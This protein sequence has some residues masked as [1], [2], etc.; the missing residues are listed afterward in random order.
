MKTP[1]VK[2]INDII[3]FVFFG[4]M[5]QTQSKIDFCRLL[6]ELLYQFGQEFKVL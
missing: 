6:M 4:M 3:D 2:G 1:V 5:H